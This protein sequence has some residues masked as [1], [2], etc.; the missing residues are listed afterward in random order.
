MLKGKSYSYF[1]V[2]LQFLLIGLLALNSN[3]RSNILY[4]L[5]FFLGI[6]VGVWAILVM[7]KSKL[8]ITPDVASN[9]TLIKTGPYK[10]I[11]HPMYL[12]VL[13]VCLSFAL[14]NINSLTILLFVFLFLDLFLKMNYE[15]KLLQ[16]AFYNYSE[17]MIK[18]KRLIPF[19]Y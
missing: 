4:L 15:E 2:S 9:A 12:S 3:L 5:I 18:T 14:S 11:R 10:Y 1:L 8:R 19:L 7:Q 17:Y 6:F 13:T 16:K